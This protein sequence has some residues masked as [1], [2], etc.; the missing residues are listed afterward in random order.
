MRAENSALRHVAKIIQTMYLPRSKDE[1]EQ[2][3]PVHS[4]VLLIMVEVEVQKTFMFIG[5]VFLTAELIH[6]A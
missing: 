5:E 4:M 6:H 3:P 2:A 1:G